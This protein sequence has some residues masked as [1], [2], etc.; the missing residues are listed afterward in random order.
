[1]KWASMIRA[2]RWPMGVM[3]AWIVFRSLWLWLQPFGAVCFDR[4]GRCIPLW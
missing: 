3:L 2:V 4:V 1:M